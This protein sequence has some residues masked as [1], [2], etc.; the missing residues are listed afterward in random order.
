MRS[1]PGLFT[2]LMIGMVD[3]GEKG[4]FLDRMCLRLAE[5]SERDYELQQSVKRE[6]W[7]PKLLVFCSILIPAA[8]PTVIA[9]ANG[10]GSPLSAFLNSVGP[11]FIFLAVCW[12]V[13]RIGSRVLPVAAHTGELRK[14][15]DGAKF[16]L[17]IMSKTTRA[18]AAAKFCRAM[19]ALYAAGM[20]MSKTVNVAA[21]AC[22]N[23]AFADRVRRIIP[24]LE[25]G[26]ELTAA[27]RS[28]G[29]FPGVAL[30][31]M[32]TGEMSGNLDEQLDKVADFMEQ[33]AET[34][35]KQSVKVLGIVVFLAVAMYIG[36]IIIGQYGVTINNV[37]DEGTKLAE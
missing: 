13:W 37:I 1:Y 6:T 17:P 7:Y 3:A 22:G 26:G 30:Q 9:G 4:G 10:T 8:I 11:P 35:I 27:L 18:L 31:M 25:R 15:L 34:A 32:Q 36:S 2:E 23:A 28:T 24:E 14:L 33:D 20:G 16:V 12:F 29:Q 5:Y 19:G 21:N